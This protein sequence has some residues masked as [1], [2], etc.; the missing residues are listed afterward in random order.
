LYTPNARTQRFSAS[1]TITAQ[2]FLPLPNI[3]VNR[4][5]ASIMIRRRNNS[6]LPIQNL[7]QNYVAI[8]YDFLQVALVKHICCWTD[9]LDIKFP[10]LPY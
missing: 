7:T 4:E 1:I 3:T 8:C 2:K 6:E 10:H 5:A 9:Y